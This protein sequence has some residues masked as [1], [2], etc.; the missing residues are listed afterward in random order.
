MKRTTL[1]LTAVA[2][3]LGTTLAGTALAQNGNAFQAG[4][5][6]A[7]FNAQYGH[8]DNG[9]GWGS[10]RDRFRAMTLEGRWVLD[11]RD[12]DFGSGRD[13]FRGR[14]RMQELQLPARITIDQRPNM[15]KIA[16]ARN[17]SLQVILLG[18]K[19]DSRHRGDQPDYAIGHWNGSTL[20]VEHEGRRGA[21]ITQTFALQNRGRILV[22][23]TRREGFGP[24][25]TEITSTYRR[26]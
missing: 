23:K 13:G 26:A 11:D 3:L 20:V 9:R 12:A 10:H 8:E 18:S 2:A 4:G 1:V 5:Q 15:V 17:R 7:F 25:A 19:F 16:D 22:V 6:A 24:R 21:T 14:G